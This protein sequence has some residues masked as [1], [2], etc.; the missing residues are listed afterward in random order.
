MCD[1]IVISTDSP[2]NLELLA[3]HSAYFSK[4]MHHLEPALSMLKHEH[5]YRLYEKVSRCGCGFRTLDPNLGFIEPQD[6]LEEDKEELE[7][8]YFAY[9]NIKRLL[10]QG[11]EVDCIAIWT[12]QQPDDNI[13]DYNKINL[14]EITRD[15]FAFLFLSYFDYYL[16]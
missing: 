5:K 13:Y 7:N 15:K 11:F 14:N 3:H 10:Q 16:E 9:D 4:D 8:T 6:W 12:T 2:E 1:Y